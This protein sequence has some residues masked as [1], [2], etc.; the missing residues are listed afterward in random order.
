MQGTPQT[1][2]LMVTSSSYIFIAGRF[3]GEFSSPWTSISDRA[4]SILGGSPSKWGPNLLLPFW[5]LE[6]MTM[7]FRTQYSLKDACASWNASHVWLHELQW[8]RE[9]RTLSSL[10]TN[11]RYAIQLSW[12]IHP[13]SRK[14][15]I[16]KLCTGEDHV[17][18]IPWYRLIIAHLKNNKNQKIF[19]LSIQSCTQYF[20]VLITKSIN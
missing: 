11:Y 14:I 9:H 20:A 13:V 8:T 19:S 16:Y 6:A 18:V 5:L 4:I 12:K 10:L 7:L 1:R 2:N 15:N 3:S 17:H